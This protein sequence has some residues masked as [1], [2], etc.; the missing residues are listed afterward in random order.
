LCRKERKCSAIH[1][2]G[3]KIRLRDE[4]ALLKNACLEKEIQKRPS[5]AKAPF[6]LL[7]LYGG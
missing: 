1:H 5:G 2:L 6:I 4:S 7:A 3:G